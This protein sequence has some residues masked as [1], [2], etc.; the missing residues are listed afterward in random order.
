MTFQEEP[1]ELHPFPPVFTSDKNIELISSVLTMFCE[2]FGEREDAF[3]VY[4]I[5]FLLFML[6]N[7]C[8]KEKVWPF[9]SVSVEEFEKDI[10]DYTTGIAC[11]V[12]NN[13]KS[14]YFLYSFS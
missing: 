7:A 12:I 9:L 1:S 10:Y 13:T 5:E 3:K 11:E 8:A 6:V 2:D 4:S 14:K